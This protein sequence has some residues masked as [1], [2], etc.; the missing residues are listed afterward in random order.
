VTQLPLF[1]PEQTWEMP[2]AF[3]RLGKV[4]AL[5]F[6]TFD[7]RL[8]TF[9]AGWCIPNG[10]R[11][12]GAALACDD[13]EEYFPISHEGGGNL[14]Q[15]L[16]IRWLKDQAKDPDR[17]WIFCHALYDMGWARR[18]G[19]HFAGRVIDIQFLEALLDE[20]ADSYSLD[21]IGERRLGERKDYRLLKE[22]LATYGLK[23]VADI[24]QL[25]SYC[26]APYG[27][28][29]AGLTLRLFRH[30]NPLIKKYNLA[31]VARLEHDQIPVLLDMRERG[32]RLDLDHI[33]RQ[34][35]EFQIRETM[36]V[37]RIKDLTNINVNAWDPT[38]IAAALVESGAVAREDL[39]RTP[40]TN[41]VSVKAD[42]LDSLTGE[43]P[44]AVRQIRRWNKARTTFLEGYLLD[45]AVGG[46][47]Y[48][49]FHPLR[50][51]D[52]GTVTG[53]YSSSLPN[54][55]NLPS[56]EKD[57]EVGTAVREG[58]LPEEGEMWAAEDYSSQE[59]RLTVHF[60]AEMRAPGAEKAVAAYRI[61]EGL[62]Y[63]QMI[64]DMCGI[65]RKP[66]KDINLGLA[67]GMGGGL[68]CKSLGLPTE[69]KEVTF[70]GGQTKTIEVAGEEGQRLLDLYHEK[71]PF[72]SFM[73]TT[74]TNQAKRNGFIETLAGRRAHFPLV[75]GERWYTHKALNRKIQ[76]SAADQV[77]YAMK[78]LFDEGF[79]ILTTIHDEVGLSV[80]SREEAERA[81]KIMCECAPLVVPLK[82]DIDIG[83]SWGAA[84]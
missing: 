68:L 55:Q 10:G 79:T 9:G 2:S 62:D 54:L 50:G 59:P 69:W 22:A 5:D 20:N 52:G 41:Q 67:Y 12:V 48:G 49:S 40:K 18:Y 39:P 32:I 44:D 53:R 33:E 23:G 58:F 75:N 26:A 13:W 51:E 64:A 83:P 3:P 71:V 66:A 8:K 57:K 35:K 63:H 19:I 21:N 81:G 30:L 60:A 72:I 76:G 37:R 78:A 25:P 73:T 15:T 29:D 14:D 65:A 11:I 56:P 7:P 16:V 74:L 47:L 6:E 1:K 27:R 82:V 61:D 36:L 45:R 4:V 77:K 46:R 17:V 38:S 70:R 24:G 34:R 84:G 31:E 80:E 28:Q 43:V 42:Y